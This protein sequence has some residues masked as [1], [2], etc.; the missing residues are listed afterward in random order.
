MRIDMKID[1][2]DALIACALREDL[3][4]IGDV[5]SESHF[6]RQVIWQK[7]LLNAKHMAFFRV[8]I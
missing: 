7:L 6:F 2:L 8:F 5:T 3:D 1:Y 4:E